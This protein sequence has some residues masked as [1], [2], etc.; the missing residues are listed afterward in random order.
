MHDSDPIA[1]VNIINRC[2]LNSIYQTTISSGTVFQHLATYGRPNV[3]LNTNM[4]KDTGHATLTKSDSKDMTF[5]VRSRIRRRKRED[6]WMTWIQRES[7]TRESVTRERSHY[8]FAAH[9]PIHAALF[10]HL[11]HLIPCP[12]DYQ[13]TVDETVITLL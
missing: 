3:I 2:N 11:Q 6:K 7:V 12:T 13:P 10:V 1:K 8:P 4:I 5:S 9:T